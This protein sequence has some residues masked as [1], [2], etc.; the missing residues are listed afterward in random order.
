MDALLKQPISVEEAIENWD[1]DGDFQGLG[2]MHFR[3]VSSTTIGSS[4]YRSVQI[5]CQHVSVAT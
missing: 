2:D 5:Q 4:Q 3:N 1:D